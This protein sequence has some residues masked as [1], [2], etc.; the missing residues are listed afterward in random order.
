VNPFDLTGKDILVTGASSGLGR[1]IAIACSEQG[2]NIFLTARDE[3]RLDETYSNLKGEGHKIIQADLRHDEEIENL[4]ISLPKLHGVVYS[5]GTST[6][7]PTGF[8]TREKFHES[9]ESNFNAVVLLNERLVRLKKLTRNE[10]S[11]VWISSI[12]IQYPFIGGGLYVSAKAA[13]EG[14]SRVFAA[15]MAKKG[16]RSNCIRPGYVKTPMTDATEELSKEAVRKIEEQQPL[17]LGT[18]EDVANTVVFFLSDASK[19][20]T[21][22]N[23]ILGGG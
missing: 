9:F 12:S 5:V 3:K 13:I 8:L 1:Q 14:Y 17:G 6:I 21:A 2:G 15:E 10:C 23:L 20:I 19:W 18:P 22:T 7:L 4:V 11:V 16:I